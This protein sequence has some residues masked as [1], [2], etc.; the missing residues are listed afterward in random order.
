MERITDLILSAIIS[1]GIVSLVISLFLKRRTEKITNEV[2][3]Q[4]EEQATVFKS[5]YVWKE[6]TLAE[7]LGPL[8]MQFCRTY[9]AF[10]RYNA[11]NLY[12][13]AKILREGNQKIRDLLLEKTYLIPIDLQEDARKL[14]EHY[15]IWLEEF[16]KLRGDSHKDL[17]E[18]FVFVGPKGYPFPKEAEK[19]LKDRYNQIWHELYK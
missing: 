5:N 16:D 1:S 18:K 19:R 2:K 10:R 4:F 15:D 11:G 17:S 8:Y 6:R 7:L 12:L 14:V 9:D 3:K 13:E